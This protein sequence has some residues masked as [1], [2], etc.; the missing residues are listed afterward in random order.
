MASEAMEQQ[1]N[2]MDSR[3]AGTTAATAAASAA[4]VMAAP[5]AIRPKLLKLPV[6]DDEQPKSGAGGHHNVHNSSGGGGGAGGGNTSSG[7]R[8]RK[9]NK[10]KVRTNGCNAFWAWFSRANANV[11]SELKFYKID[12]TLLN[13]SYTV[14][15][16][17]TVNMI[18][19]WR[20]A[21]L[22]TKYIS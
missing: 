1:F 20:V 14:H 13:R 10:F 7:Q 18:T 4:T 8:N 15:W 16:S 22:I 9:K 11:L 3:T 17:Y 6:V 5:R 12:S 19:T 2:A 21:R